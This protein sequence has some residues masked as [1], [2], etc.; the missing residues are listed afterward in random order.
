MY[1]IGTP[2]PVQRGGQ[3]ITLRRG[4]QHHAVEVTAGNVVLEPHP[5]VPRT[6]DDDDD[7]EA[8]RGER[9]DDAVHQRAEER[10]A[11]DPAL[12]LGDD[13]S[14]RVGPGGDELAGGEVGQVPGDSDCFTY[15]LFELGAHRRGVAHDP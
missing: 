5:V 10:L 9:L 3:R 1:T 4:D 8:G 14:D 2:E 15:C 7:V 6:G 13:H 12:V 11:E